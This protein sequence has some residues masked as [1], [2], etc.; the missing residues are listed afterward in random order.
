MGDLVTALEIARAIQKDIPKRGRPTDKPSA[1]ETDQVLPASLFTGTRGYLEK[2]AF[3][4]NGCYEQGWFDA[5]AVMM[6]RLLETLIIEA[7]EHH[8]ITHKI[9]NG[10]DD[11]VYLSDLIGA[12]LAEKPWNLSRNAKRALP[13]LK[14]IGDQSAHSRRFIAH[15]SDIERVRGPMRTVTQELLIIANLA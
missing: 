7:F 1:P 12:T 3:Q 11:F 15:R 4:V 9:K 5:C 2:I 8:G 13:K 6:R 14:E 10:N